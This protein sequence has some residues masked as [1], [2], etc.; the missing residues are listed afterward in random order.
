MHSGLSNFLWGL[1]VWLWASASFPQIAQFIE[2]GRSKEAVRILTDVIKYLLLLMIPATVGL[3]VLGHDIVRVVYDRGEF[4]RK[5]WLEPTY[6]AL[7]FYAFGLF[8]YSLT[9]VLVQF[10]QAHHDFRRPVYYG[11]VNFLTNVTLCL[12]FTHYLPLWS[13]ALASAI[14]SIV[15]CGFLLTDSVRRAKEF[16][17]APILLFGGKVIIAAAVMGGH[18]LFLFAGDPYCSNQFS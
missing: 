13:L 5:E 7:T 17:F 10:I 12:V 11:L 2:Q 3:A 9:K 6:M 8:F 15:Q 4:H 16:S 1:L 14:A 18:V